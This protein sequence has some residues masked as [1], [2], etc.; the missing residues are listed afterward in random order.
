PLAA[1]RTHFMTGPLQPSYS[2]TGSG[3]FW[4]MGDLI[5]QIHGLGEAGIEPDGAGGQIGGSQRSHVERMRLGFGEN[6]VLANLQ[7]CC[8]LWIGTEPLARR[9]SHCNQ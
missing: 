3:L 7:R 9:C 4:R 1:D 6:A 8:D 5:A 2:A